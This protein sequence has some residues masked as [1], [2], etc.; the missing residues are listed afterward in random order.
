MDHPQVSLSTTPVIPVAVD[1]IVDNISRYKML[2]TYNAEAVY[3][4]FCAHLLLLD[5]LWSHIRI[6]AHK[7]QVVLVTKI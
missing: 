6:S 7:N 5:T 1:Q 2:M 3:I 4:T